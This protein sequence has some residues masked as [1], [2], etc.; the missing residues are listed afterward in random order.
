MSR[1][2]PKSRAIC[3][4]G[5]D[6]KDIMAEPKERNADSRWVG[7]TWGEENRKIEEGSSPVK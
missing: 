4:L 6:T 5:E 3:I 7:G 1:P 2:F